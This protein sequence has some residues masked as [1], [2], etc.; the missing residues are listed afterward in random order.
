MENKRTGY[1]DPWSVLGVCVYIYTYIKQPQVNMFQE[2]R[3]NECKMSFSVN[4]IQS[5]ST[6]EINTITIKITEMAI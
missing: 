6:T 3:L 5:N 2:Q 4:Y 1:P